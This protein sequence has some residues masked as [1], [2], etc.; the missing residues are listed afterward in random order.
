MDN[1]TIEK[2]N[3]ELL[4]GEFTAWEA[5]K[6]IVSFLDQKINF[7]KLRNLSHQEGS[8]K[9]LAQSVQRIKELQ[10]SKQT[11]LDTIKEAKM[12]RSRLSIHAK[13]SVELV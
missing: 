13:I 11:F 4:G 8:G 3:F 2:L 5:E 10:E 7:H 12:N 1:T 6:L 9:P